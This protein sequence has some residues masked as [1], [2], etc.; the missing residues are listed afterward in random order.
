MNAFRTVLFF[1]AFAE[2]TLGFGGFRNVVNEDKFAVLH[3]NTHEY[4]YGDTEDPE[5]F[6]AASIK[7]LDDPNQ[8]YALKMLH[9]GIKLYKKFTKQMPKFRSVDTLHELLH[10]ETHWFTTRK[11]EFR[12][13]NEELNY[14]EAQAYCR[15]RNSHLPQF[16]T[17]SEVDQFAEQQRKMTARDSKYEDTWIGF[18]RIDGNFKSEFGQFPESEAPLRFAYDEPNEEHNDCLF[19]NTYGTYEAIYDSDCDNRRYFSCQYFL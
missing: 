15:N 12:F 9:D 3:K 6:I 18:R 4:N 17:W 19:I 5:A 14:I 8:A 1:L 11:V 10:E 16:H 7:E 2:S 13:I